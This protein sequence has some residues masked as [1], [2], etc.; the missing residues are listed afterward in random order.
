MNI[1]HSSFPN[2]YS[3][4]YPSYLEILLITYLSHCVGGNISTAFFLE[5]REATKVRII[6]ISPATTAIVCSPPVKP[7][8]TSGVKP[9]VM[10]APKIKVSILRTIIGTINC[11]ILSNIFTPD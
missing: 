1:F 11:F 8:A 10:S 6:P 9:K 4:E 2:L 5:K 3:W 7:V